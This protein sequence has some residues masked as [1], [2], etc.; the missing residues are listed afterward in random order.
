MFL[1]SNF[2]L[3]FYG[4]NTALP[5]LHKTLFIIVFK[6]GRGEELAV[7][8]SDTELF[9]CLCLYVTII[10]FRMENPICTSS[11]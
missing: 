1:L 2:F 3:I 11:D 9:V 8:F 6:K 10:E 7:S 5:I 4:I